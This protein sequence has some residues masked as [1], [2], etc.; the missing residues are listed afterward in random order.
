M[1]TDTIREFTIQT[2]K[3]FAKII[4]P[5]RIRLVEEGGSHSVEYARGW[6]DCVQQTNHN[7]QK[8]IAQIEDKTIGFRKELKTKP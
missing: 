5:W 8:T 6:N 4:K 2:L 1:N 7:I 3:T